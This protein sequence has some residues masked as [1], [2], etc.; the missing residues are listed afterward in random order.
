MK[1][2]FINASRRYG[3]HIGDG[4]L[5]E[6]G[7][8]IRAL[9]KAKK[10]ALVCDDTVH[11]LYASA[12]RG[13]LE[14]AG[15][16]VHEYVFAHGE[17]SKSM[18]ELVRLLE[19]LAGHGMTRGDVIT[20]LGG[21]VTGDL[22]GFAASV[23]LRGMDYVQL[24][25]TLLAAIDSAIGG[26]TA[27]NLEAGKNLAGSVYQ[28]IAVLCDTSLLKTL[29]EDMF[30]S[31]TAEAIKYGMVFDESLFSQLEHGDYKDKLEDI[32]AACVTYKAAMVE[33]DEFDTGQRHLL[34]FGHTIGHAIEKCSNYALPHGH[35]VAIGMLYMCRAAEKLGLT[36]AACSERLDAAL[37]ANGLPVSTDY[38]AAQLAKYAL[39]DKKRQGDTITLVIPERIGKCG[40]H[41][42]PVDELEAFIAAGE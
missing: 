14:A 42:L 3:V 29:P 16:E 8:H 28:P 9:T 36:K 5:T 31:G 41:K 10:A 17:A 18:T 15:F 4:L 33:R 38:T 11:A 25:T 21:G 40:L 20:A 19:F 35:G 32:V 26:K 6:A 2:V 37:K 7:G 22:A 34:N 23:Y 30:A 13:S 27:V 39:S 12:L 24:P 1:S